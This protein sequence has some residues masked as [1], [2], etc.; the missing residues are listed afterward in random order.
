VAAVRMVLSISLLLSGT[1]GVELGTKEVCDETHD[2]LAPDRYQ[3][4]KVW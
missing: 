3:N 4:G 1:P 2:R